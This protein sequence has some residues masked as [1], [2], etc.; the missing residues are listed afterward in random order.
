MTTTSWNARTDSLVG[1]ERV[2]D[3]RLRDD[4]ADERDADQARDPGDGV[5]DGRGDAGVALVGVGEHGRRQ[6][7]H[8]HREP[9]AEQEQ[10]RQ[11]VREVRTSSMPVRRRSRIPAA[12]TI[13]P[14]PMNRRG[15]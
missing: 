12:A 11:D 4:D 7:R 14:T 13:G 8:R 10:R 2:A 9:E 15:P 5:V 6:R 1:G 3:E